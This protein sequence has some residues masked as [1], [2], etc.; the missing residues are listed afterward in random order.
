[1]LK[2]KKFELSNIVVALTA[3]IS[4]AAGLSLL[5]PLLALNLEVR[6][7][8]ELVIGLMGSTTGV[9]VIFAPF[10][11]H[12]IVRFLN[13]YQIF[14]GAFLLA[15]ITT[16]LHKLFYSVELWLILRFFSAVGFTLIFI[17]IDNW[18]TSKY[19]EKNNLFILGFYAVTFSMGYAL[20]PL[21]LS[22]FDIYTW[23]PYNTIL[24]LC[25][26]PLIILFF[27]KKSLS[28]EVVKKNR[29]FL[30]LF[31]V[32]PIA[33]CSAYMTGAMEVGMADL[34]PI[35]GRNLDMSTRDSALL[36]TFYS[37]GGIFTQL[38]LIWAFRYV[39]KNTAVIISGIGIVLGGVLIPFT[40]G[41]NLLYVIIILLSGFMLVLFPLGLAILSEKFSKTDLLRANTLFGL[42]YGVGAF[43]GPMWIGYLMHSLA[44]SGFPLA[45]ITLGIM[46]ILMV[47]YFLWWQHEEKT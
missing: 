28:L 8:S 16:V 23:L 15:M 2:K 12:F 21:I 43:T 6:G 31:I 42:A 29:I 14:V 45:L 26:L 34:L 47:R 40:S 25:T 44:N 37:L 33:F 39:S 1:M 36:L 22:I 30:K 38:L 3:N 46:F 13:L 20:G 19:K 4:V 35:F 41:S 17:I 10:F 18:V 5:V 7:E 11:L 27:G 32:A 9:G 24:L